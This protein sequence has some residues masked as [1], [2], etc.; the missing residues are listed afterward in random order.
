MKTNILIILSSVVISISCSNVEQT[1]DSEET[2]GH[3]DSFLKKSD[4]TTKLIQSS[5]V[6]VEKTT[7]LALCLG[8]FKTSYPE[9]YSSIEGASNGWDFAKQLKRSKAFEKI[10]LSYK[11]D[12]GSMQFIERED[13]K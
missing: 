6:D 4:S 3:L 10:A 11:L 13:F 1:N 8:E 7:K 12:I 2:K 9:E 5:G